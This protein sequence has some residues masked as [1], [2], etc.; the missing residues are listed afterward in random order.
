MSLSREADILEP[1]FANLSGMADL[2]QAFE[3]KPR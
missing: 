3:Q 2:F 1:K